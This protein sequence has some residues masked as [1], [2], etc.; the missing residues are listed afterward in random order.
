MPRTPLSKAPADEAQTA[1]ETNSRR[2]PLTDGGRPV[3]SAGK[4]WGA[5]RNNKQKRSNFAQDFKVP[6]GDEVLIKF[7]DDEPFDSYYRHWL[8]GVKGRQTYVCL[9][10]NCPLC[11]IGDDPGFVVLFNVVDVLTD[12]TT[13]QV[14]SASPNPAGAIETMATGKSSS[15][16]NRD[17][18]YFSV[19]KKKG[20][21]GYF[22]Y[23]L[24]PVKSRDLPDDWD[25]QPLSDEA[26]AKLAEGKNGSDFIKADT[27]EV[28]R[29]VVDSMED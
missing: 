13:V 25:I 19:T 5:Y 23:T 16:I 1:P 12:P 18:L 3:G 22:G 6:E 21:N 11:D 8:R 24:Q 27:R 20:S 26:L 28:L 9:G 2:P 17:D 4:G 10:D 14:W 7:L 29:E 15:P